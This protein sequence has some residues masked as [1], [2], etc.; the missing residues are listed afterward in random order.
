YKEKVLFD[1][2]YQFIMRY[3]E[4]FLYE[5]DNIKFLLKIMFI[6]PTHLQEEVIANVYNYYMELEK[7]IEQ[8]FYEQQELLKVDYQKAKDAF[9]NVID[10][11]L[12]E[13]SYVSVESFDKRL[14]ASWEIF[15]NGVE[16]D[17]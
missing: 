14:N 13:L 4:R 3:R 16:N 2:L 10:G 8:L 1:V 12:V 9:L 11:L 5:N 6:P 7:F 15:K 17:I